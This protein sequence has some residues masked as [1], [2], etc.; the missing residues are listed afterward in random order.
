VGPSTTEI[1][2]AQGYATAAAGSAT[3][4]SVSAY[5]AAD[6]ANLAQLWATEAEDV[7]VWPGL[8]SA[9]HWSA[10]S[11]SSAGRA[12]V[13]R[14]EAQGVLPDRLRRDVTTLLADTT[15]TYTAGQPGTVV[16]GDIIHT[17]ADDF[18]YEVALSSATDHHVT[19]AGVVK[20]YGLVGSDGRLNVK[21][22]GAVGDGV[23]DDTQ[24]IQKAINAGSFMSGIPEIYIPAGKYV[25]STIYLC[26]D[27]TNNPGFNTAIPEG[28]VTL[29]GAGSIGIQAVSRASSLLAK[30]TV[31]LATSGAA[32]SIV[33]SLVDAS[34]YSIRKQQIKNLTIISDTTDY[35]IR[36]P[37]A[38]QGSLLEDVSVRVESATGSGVLWGA[39]WYST[40]SRVSISQTTDAPVSS[41]DGVLFQSS[42]FAGLYGFFSCAFQG[43]TNT[44]R[45]G[46]MANSVNFAFYNCA[47]EGAAADGVNIPDSVGTISFRD[48]YFE[49]NDGRHIRINGRAAGR[50]VKTLLVENCFF[51]GNNVAPAQTDEMILLDGCRAADLRNNYFWRPQSNIIN[52]VFDA[53]YGTGSNLTVEGNVVDLSGA[54][55]GSEVHHLVVMSARSARPVLSRNFIPVSANLKE[56]DD[57]T[58]SDI[59]LTRVT[60]SRVTGALSSGLVYRRDLATVSLGDTMPSGGATTRIFT[61]TAAGVAAK[62][63]AAPQGAQYFVGN[64][65]ASTL[66]LIVRNSSNTDLAT[67]T[68]GR[69]L[70]LVADP[71]APQGFIRYETAFTG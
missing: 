13:A 24:P 9:F 52:N 39:S 36:N 54:T 65:T 29:V 26:R 7:E 30:G 10:K 55:Y 57:T 42:I 63:E 59:A 25:I 56:Y 50:T 37:S 6:K 11:A 32:S 31:L 15:L 4:A 46:S 35:A 48:C 68:P 28:L 51:Y 8:F 19:T 38:P 17:Q 22:F 20:L 60:G 21:A 67:I 23:A 18:Y 47:F 43:F 64:A 40:W 58:Y 44:V 45:F 41:G 33:M 49:Y 3:A 34:P 70:V 61:C 2:S 5:L 1:S 71:A 16:A 53:T 14:D 69:A 62:L 12:E 27:A 66:N